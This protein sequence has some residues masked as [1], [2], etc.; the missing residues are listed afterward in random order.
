MAVRGRIL[1]GYRMWKHGKWITQ[2][3]PTPIPVYGNGHMCEQCSP[4]FKICKGK[5]YWG[6]IELI[7]ERKPITK[8]E[9]VTLQTVELETMEAEIEQASIKPPTMTLDNVIIEYPFPGKSDP[10]T[11]KFKDPHPICKYCGEELMRGRSKDGS[12]FCKSTVNKQV[13][14]P[15][16]AAIDQAAYTYFIQQRGKSK[17]GKAFDKDVNFDN[18]K[19]G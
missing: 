16:K 7:Y 5:P 1:Y 13:H 10:K 12:G 11:T 19:K 17:M 18:I 14:V 6:M 2:P 8:R 4:K 9:P 15:V 3:L